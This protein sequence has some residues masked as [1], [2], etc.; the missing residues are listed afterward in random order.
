[1][2]K[3]A[4]F[5]NLK[6][7]GGLNHLENITIGLLKKG[8]IIDQYSHQEIK[9]KGVDKNYY[10]PIKQSRNSITQTF[11]SIIELSV[12]Q[13]YI[14]KEI[15][16]KNYDFIFVFPC[17]ITQSPHILRYLPKQKTYYFFLEPKREFYEK[18]SFDY[19]S[20]KRIVSRIIRYPIKIFDKYNCVSSKNI[21][22][23]SI[24]SQNNLKKIYNK[25]SIN[26]YP[27]MRTVIPKKISVKNY[28][29]FLSFGLLSM[30]KGHHLSAKLISNVDIFGEY[31]HENIRKYL[32]AHVSI[33][34]NVKEKDKINTYNKYSFFLANQINES[35]G[36]TTLEATT[37]NCYI[38]GRNEGGTS[39]IV[40]NGLNGLLFPQNFQTEKKYIRNFNKKDKISFYNT[41]IID[42]DHTV[43]QIIRIINL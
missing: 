18:T 14:A 5:H 13:K 21:I 3:I 24:F 6:K 42:W 10:Y 38:F 12:S 15:S 41:C 36:L 35:F 32:P 2:K 43:S 40:K 11:Q 31:S 25:N 16:Q 17:N 1:M 26:I 19:Y 30:L 20:I 7:G 27:G 33:H 9:L 28:H 4:I 29:N 34:N 22:S 39:E 23:N 37:N 8:Y